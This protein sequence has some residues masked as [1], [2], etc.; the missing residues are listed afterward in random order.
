L[1]YSFSIDSGPYSSTNSFTISGGT[2]SF[3]IK[4]NLGCINS[5]VLFI[6]QPSIL[7]APVVSVT[8]PP[9]CTIP[10]GTI[11]VTSPSGAGIQ[12]SIG[13]AYQSSRTFSNLVPHTYQV[14]TKDVNTGCISA[15]TNITVDPVP[16]DPAAPTAFVKVQPTC[17]TPTGIIVVAAPTGINIE[18]SIGGTFQSNGTF[19]NLAPNSYSV[20]VKDVNTG[21]ISSITNLTI[22]TIPAA[23]FAPTVSLTVQPTCIVPTGTIEVTAPV[24]PNLQYSIGTFYQL[25]GIFS[26]LAPNSYVVTVKDILTGCISQ[27]TSLIVKPPLNNLL[28]PIA[29]S[30]GRCG[31]GNLLLT[32][33][34]SGLINWYDDSGLNNLIYSGT[35]FNSYLDAT[36]KYYV[37]TASGS[38]KSSAT[39]V[40][41]FVYPTPKPTLFTDSFLCPGEKIVLYPGVYNI[42]LWQDNS[43]LPTFTVSAVGT[44]TVIVTLDPG[45]CKDSASIKIS[46]LSNCNDIYFPNAFSP[47]AD[48]INSKFGPIGKLSDITN[49]SLT[50]YNRLGEIVFRSN[51]PYEKWD[52]RYRGQPMNTGNFVWFANY[53]FKG[54]VNTKKGNLLLIK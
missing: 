25:S 53:V 18:Y 32:A 24:G 11:L 38:C 12:Y 16:A 42:Y 37:I 9:T 26:I 41:G 17:T 54:A 43:D 8:R 51:N 35:N 7:T 28:Q 34:G 44:Y 13:R 29:N 33:S 49:F 50:I 47:N 20:T 4:D 46:Y 3:N 1:P 2:H 36:K 27:A 31:K 23:P 39:S 22:N 19:S 40:T 48:L 15:V 6:S 45:G 52:G 30:A 5:S 10:T 14:T 21:C